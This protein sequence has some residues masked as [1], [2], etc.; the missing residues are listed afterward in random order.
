MFRGNSI[1]A[2]RSALQ[3]IGNAHFNKGEFHE[4]SVLRERI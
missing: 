2:D 1:H 4:S 3:N